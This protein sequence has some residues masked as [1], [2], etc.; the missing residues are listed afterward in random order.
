M[1][2]GN[3]FHAILPPNLKSGAGKSF[4]ESVRQ[5]L[6]GH[7]SEADA[8]LKVYNVTPE[9]A[10]NEAFSAIAHFG[11]DICFHAA[12][13]QLARGYSGKAFVYHFNMPNPWEGPWKGVPGHI[14]DVAVLF[15][16]YHDRL[17]AEDRDISEKYATHVIEFIAGI[18]PYP[19]FSSD[20]GAMVYGPPGKGAD[21]ITGNDL[22]KLGR[23]ADLVPIAEQVGYDALFQ[24]WMAFTTSK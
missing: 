24:A 5:S 22:N 7:P 9:L 19:R 13:T 11:T 14:F 1:A 16:N 18:E 10:D 6:R 12:T 2:K 8:L 17:S 4:C 3:V 21:F 23:R 15:M 20:G